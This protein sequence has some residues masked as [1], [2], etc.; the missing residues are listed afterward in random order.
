MQSYEH[1]MER[2]VEYAERAETVSPASVEFANLIEAAKFWQSTARE[3][4]LGTVKTRTYG[5]IR[6]E[7]GVMRVDAP[8]PAP[9]I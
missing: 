4:R 9:A 7:K 3:L 8:E 1:A 6:A 2:A 5:S